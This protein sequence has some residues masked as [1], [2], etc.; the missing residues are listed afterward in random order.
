LLRIWQVSSP[1]SERIEQVLVTQGDLVTLGQELIILRTKEIEYQLFQLKN[2]LR[3][4]RIQAD[5]ARSSGK[6]FEAKMVDAE[7]GVTQA[8]LDL[9]LYKI[10]Q[11]RIKAPIAGIITQGNLDDMVGEVISPDQPILEIAQL[12]TLTAIILVP[13]SG[14]TRVEPGQVGQ[15]AL[16]ARPGVKLEYVVESITPA[17]EIFQ[18]QNVYRVE[19]E[20]Q[21]PPDWLRPGMEGQAK[22]YGGR[23]N[24]FTIYTRP[25][26]DAIRLRL[27]W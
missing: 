25:L 10:S 19:V 5:E 16:S 8:D 6:I 20:L 18:Q 3:R 11:S 17:S 24:L 15:L 1:F 7:I 26:F 22:I 4:L 21:D 12:S 27:W 14:V 9:I 23:T 13:E 2:Q